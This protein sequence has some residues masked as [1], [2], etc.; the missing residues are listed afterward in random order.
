MVPVIELSNITK[1]FTERSLRSLLFRMAP[2]KIEAL[3]GITLSVGSGEVFGLLGPNGAGKTTLIKILATLILPDNGSG[4]ICGH[5][6]WKESHQV[7]R[8]IGFVNAGERSFY[9]RL[10]GRQNLR[11]FAALHDLH[12][13]GRNKRI[14][15]LL[16]LVGLAEKADTS[17]MK[18]SDGQKQRL[19]IARALLSDPRVLLMDE[20]T[21]SVDPIGARELIDLTVHELAR[22]RGKTILWSTHNLNEAE[23]VCS[24][25]A[26]IHRG[27]IIASGDLNHMRSLIDAES[28]YRMKIDDCHPDV[29]HTMGITPF[30]MVRNNGCIE[31]ELKRKE[32]DIP[33]LI[34]RLVQSGIHVHACTNRE[35]ELEE[36]FEKLVRH[37]CY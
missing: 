1:T 25:L 37:E 11:F 5:D 13:F 24:R 4:T 27:T 36:V 18:Y 17:F 28:L 15:E 35:A 30:E 31:F 26:V 2:G 16:E 20:P 10:T 32:T 14:A 34:Q 19:A 33:I 29:L 12:G 6:L 21:K 7:R 23:K 3:K 9:W 22:K 8:I